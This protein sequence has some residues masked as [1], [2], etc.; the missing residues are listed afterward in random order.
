MN[1]LITAFIAGLLF[2]IGLIVSGMTNPAKVIGFLDVTGAWDP[3]LAL[4]MA[5]AI[6][7]AFPAFWLARGR[8][9]TCLGEPM[10][11]PASSK[12]DKPLLAG[13]LLFGIGWGLAGYCPGPIVAS[14][15]TGA[16]QPWIIFVAM[17]AG[18]GLYE[19]YQH[20]AAR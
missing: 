16:E 10:Q 6:L 12:V 20:V 2:G 3:S 19:L 9:Q 14:L 17:L 13:A 5:G 8:Q 4:V 11:L 18:M 1:T 15:A 7:V